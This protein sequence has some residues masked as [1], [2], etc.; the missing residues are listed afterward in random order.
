MIKLIDGGS[1]ATALTI[2]VECIHHSP[3]EDDRMRSK[4]DLFCLASE[5]PKMIDFVT[6]Q[7][8][9][10][11]TNSLGMRVF[12]REKYALCRDINTNGQCLD[13]EPIQTKQPFLAKVLSKIKERG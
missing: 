11:I 7:L 13:F 5:R 12:T 3:Y 4:R 10:L 8:G 6:G 1:K 2:C 9:F